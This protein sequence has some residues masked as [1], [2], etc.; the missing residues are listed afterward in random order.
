MQSTH[1]NH[2]QVVQEWNGIEVYTI[3]GKFGL[4]HPENDILVPPIYDSIEWDKTSDFVVVEYNGNT[5]FLSAEDGHFIYFDE[6]TDDPYMMAISYEEY[7]Q[8]EWPDWMINV[9]NYK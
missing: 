2:S 4:H 1:Y 3:D 8:E 5:G 9:K 7:M 6:E